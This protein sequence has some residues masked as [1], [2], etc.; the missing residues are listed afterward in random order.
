M[1]KSQIQ[2]ENGHK[3]AV[4]E[5]SFSNRYEPNEHLHGCRNAES[6]RGLWVLILNGQREVAWRGMWGLGLIALR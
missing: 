5:I 3:V 1:S 4:S 2:R 6:Q